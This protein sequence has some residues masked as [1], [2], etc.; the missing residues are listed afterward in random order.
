MNAQR[1]GS[2]KT[3]TI[4][5]YCLL[6]MQL[7][8]TLEVV[9]KDKETVSAWRSLKFKQIMYKCCDIEPNKLKANQ[10]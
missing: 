6:Q 3:F 9:Q 5:H 10:Q 1:S 2:A 8:N 4:Q 7:Q